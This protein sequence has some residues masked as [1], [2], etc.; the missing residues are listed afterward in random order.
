MDEEYK[1]GGRKIEGTLR[2]VSNNTLCLSMVR[3]E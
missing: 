1:D 2:G 3:Y